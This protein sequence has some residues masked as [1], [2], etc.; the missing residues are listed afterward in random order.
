MVRAIIILVGAYL[1]VLSALHLYQEK[2]IFNSSAIEILPE[3]EGKNIEHITFECEDGSMLDGVYKKATVANAPLLLYFGGNADDATRFVLH[4]EG[5]ENYDM[6]AF[7]YRG[8]VRSTGKPSEKSLFE[9]ALKIYDT[10]AKGKKVVLVGRSLG[11]G[12]ATFVASKRQTQGL[13]LITPYDSIASVA[14]R[15][16]PIFPIASMIKHKFETIR[17]IGDVH[18]KIA[19]IEVENDKTI[20]VYHLKKLLEKMPKEPLHVKLANTT[21]GRVLEHADFEDEMKK[22]LGKISE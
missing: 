16:Y 15:K 7:N 11:T 4:V 20:P 19:V 17:Y 18:A 5:I 3:V 21:H 10:Y 14:Q 22:I 13:V 12:V 9:D 1:L 8:Y 2:I 6:V